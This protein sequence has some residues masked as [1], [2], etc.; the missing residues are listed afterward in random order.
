MYRKK[1]LPEVGDFVIC[2]IKQVLPN[3]A[4]VELDEYESLEGMI[5]A[6][7]LSRRWTR[8]MKTFLKVGE[9]LVCKVMDVDREARHIN[10]SVRRVGA[11]QARTKQQEWKNE[12]TAYDILQ[13]L[14]KNTGQTIDQ[15][16]KKVGDKI[17]DK[18]GLLYPLFLEIARGVAVPLHEL[19]VEKGLAQ[20]LTQLVQKRITIP[21]AKVLG[22]LNLSSSAPNGVDVIK[23]A[24]QSIISNAQRGSITVEIKYLGAPRYNIKLVAEDH[25]VLDEFVKVEIPKVETFMRAH[26]GSATFVRK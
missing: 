20:A 10:L 22:V 18:Y 9:K 21:K 25:R 13:V 23:S 19:G 2:T 14:A 11:S 5:H 12:K 3:S 17:L 26:A 15:L 4:F 24:I 8:S 6:S 7:E 1:G 16:Y